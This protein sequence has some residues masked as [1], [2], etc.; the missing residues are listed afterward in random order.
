MKYK[1]EV[2]RFRKWRPFCKTLFR[3]HGAHLAS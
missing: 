1:P 3:R 2:T